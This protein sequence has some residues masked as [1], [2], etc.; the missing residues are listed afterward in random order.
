MIRGACFAKYMKYRIL[1]E[2]SDGKSTY[3]PQYKR[4]WFS[5]WDY[6]W[7]YDNV[8]IDD[9]DRDYVYAFEFDTLFPGAINFIKQEQE[10]QKSKENSKTKFVIHKYP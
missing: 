1:E 6:F 5:G 4:H 2:I 9:M 7:D 10:K 3:Y 8:D